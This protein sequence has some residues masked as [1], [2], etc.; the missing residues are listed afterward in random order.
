MPISY[1]PHWLPVVVV[2]SVA[3]C[4]STHCS[5]TKGV[6]TDEDPATT[7]SSQ[8]AAAGSTAPRKPPALGVE[9]CAVDVKPRYLRLDRAGG[10]AQLEVTA[11]SDCS[12]DLV[13]GLDWVSAQKVQAAGEGGRTTTVRV[14]VPANEG[15]DRIGV[16]RVAELPVAVAQAGSGPVT[17]HP[18]L[19]IRSQDVPALRARATKDNPAYRAVLKVAEE[20]QELFDKELFP[21]GKPARPWPDEGSGNLHD[22]YAEETAVIFAYLSLVAPDE[23]E[24]TKYAAQAKQVLMYMIR[25][26]NKPGEGPF[27]ADFGNG[28]R[29][30]YNG[31]QWGLIVDW[32]YPHFT[33]EE[34][35]AIRR[36]FVSWSE[37]QAKE[38]AWFRDREPRNDPGA[39][40]GIE[41][42]WI[43]NN[44]YAGTARNLIMQAMSLDPV[45][46]PKGELRAYFDEGVKNLLYIQHHVLGEGGDASGG[47]P[48]EGPFAYGMEATECV[49]D[50]LLALLTAG[51]VDPQKWGAQ[52]TFFVGDRY[53]TD[54]IAFYRQLMEPRPGPVLGENFIGYEGPHSEQRPG[55]AAYSFWQIEQHT[56]IGVAAH[57]TGNLAL[58][59][60]VRWLLLDGSADGAEE[61][62]SRA[63]T[64]SSR[65]ILTH[66]LLDPKLPPPK[67]FGNDLP[68]TFYA[69][70]QG[71]LLTRSDWGPDA[72]WFGATCNWKTI[73]HQIETCGTFHFYFDGEW[74]SQPFNGYAGSGFADSPDYFNA[75]AIQNHPTETE[76]W[77]AEYLRRGGQTRYNL[78]NPSHA[79]GDYK[80]FVVMTTDSTTLYNREDSPPAREVIQGAR[81][82]VYLRPNALVIHDRAE[83]K[84]KGLFKRFWMNLPSKPD[85]QGRQLRSRNGGLQ[86]RL[87]TLLPASAVIT[88]AKVEDLDGL[89]PPQIQ[90]MK[91]HVRVE[92]PAKPQR[93][94]MLNVIQGFSDKAAEAKPAPLAGLPAGFD[95]AALGQYAVVLVGERAPIDAGGL[96]YTVPAGVT[97]HIF[98]GLP[99]GDSYD[100]QVADGKLAISAGTAFEVDPVGVMTYRAPA[101]GAQ[102]E[103][104]SGKPAPR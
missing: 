32:L 93:L 89:A 2:I 68:L 72:G 24:R 56:P 49:V 31:E 28:E 88:E 67:D 19:W 86:I 102:T 17:G 82:F 90:I 60:R 58:R 35:T 55:P 81:T 16:L 79:V 37:W 75:M 87:D 10:E 46:D 61:L 77:D 52:A 85:I 4:A 50:G 14:S 57:L 6:R 34:R 25:E 91:T 101:I 59:D 64:G 23:A 51:Y 74:V 62:E 7:V 92:D 9:S 11:Q 43:V 69:Q 8:T 22:T 38:T 21:G 70:S 73:D 48:V 45:D 47:V 44:T 54:M 12:W 65:A 100:V 103:D 53:F 63:A 26:A 84:R 97:R 1:R 66:I 99:P 98:V 3:A 80:D 96:T 104:P 29:L 71:R 41:S 15:P 20:H 94:R 5:R 76:D 13:F 42:R 18:R 95:G 78:G 33:A 36:A 40:R 30:R 83:T 27:R 39:L